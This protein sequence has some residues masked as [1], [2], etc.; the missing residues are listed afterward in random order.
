MSRTSLVLGVLAVL[1]VGLLA[2][3]GWLT[4]QTLELER[5]EAASR[6]RAEEEERVRLALWRMD[7]VLTPF[8]A[9]E[10]SRPADDYTALP[11]GSQWKGSPELRSFLSLVRGHFELEPGE[12][13]ETRSSRP[14]PDRGGSQQALTTLVAELDPEALLSALEEPPSAPRSE[15]VASASPEPAGSKTR[16]D[17]LDFRRRTQNVALQVAFIAPEVAIETVLQPVWNGDDLLLVR[18]V[19][20]DGETVLQGS[21]L[22]LPELE[23]WLLSQVHDLLPEATL[24][25]IRSDGDAVPGRR[26]ALL[27]LALEPG[28]IPLAPASSAS[29]LRLTLGLAWLAALVTLAAAGVLLAGA[30]QLSA[31][32]ADF[33][34]AVTHE[35]RTPLTTFRIYT[36]MLAEGMAPAERREEYLETLHREAERLDH[37]VGNVLAFSRLERGASPDTTPTTA[38]E[39]LTR[40]EP[41]LRG[42]AESEGRELVVEI[43]PGAEEARLR[44]DP[45]AVERIVFNLVD[46]ACKYGRLEGAGSGDA[47]I[48]LEAGLSRRG[49]R[50]LLRL[51]DH[52]PGIPAS[53]ANRIF[54]PFH[55]SAHRAAGSAP[56]V[57]LGLA[58][59]RRL[60]RRLCGELRLVGSEE[61]AV[62]ELELPVLTTT[63][64]AGPGE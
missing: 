45:E 56:G 54:R 42:R 47:R 48:H 5:T 57:G 53:E 21:W 28:E 13:P 29:S 20:W 2:A 22:D 49:K 58:L 31:R 30:L 61:G 33:V 38:V 8:V 34:S 36:E 43:E 40:I 1:A 11:P 9:L 44:T 27:P 46:N 41:A 55:R 50:L 64:I 14:T 59:G 3:L 32:R 4:F 23:A 19:S 16:S 18:R 17:E 62:F 37:L 39:L 52:G 60:A 35:L 26:L 7:S 6:Q 24:R 12:E 25:P 15:A 63:D 10:N 51:R